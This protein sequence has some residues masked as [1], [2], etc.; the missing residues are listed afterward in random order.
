LSHDHLSTYRM[1]FEDPEKKRVPRR[2]RQQIEHSS[3][4]GLG[5][6]ETVAR[7]S[8]PQKP[9]QISPQCQE[10]VPQLSI[11]GQTEEQMSRSQQT[12]GQ[13]P[14]NQGNTE[15]SYS[16]R[17]TTG[18]MTKS[19]WSTERPSS[20]RQ[21]TRRVGEPPTF[22]DRVI[23]PPG[24]ARRAVPVSPFADAIQQSS[25]ARTR[26]TPVMPR[27]HAEDPG[28]QLRRQRQIPILHVYSALSERLSDVSSY[29]EPDSPSKGRGRKAQVPK[30]SIGIGIE[31]ELLLESRDPSKRETYVGR[32]GPI[33]LGETVAE[34]YN[35]LVPPSYPRMH[36]LVGCGKAHPCD[37][38]DTW[39]LMDDISIETTSAPCKCCIFCYYPSNH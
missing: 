4:Q 27:T 36:S 33:K 28:S 9:E 39:T 34:L 38:F 23:P 32:N 22:A 37:E 18:Q 15:Q 17:R 21:A 30:N 24:R 29:G 8:T 14:R 5:S 12:T 19:P 1:C 31:T 20:P 13:I 11:P 35:L 2:R 3:A 25:L 16:P 26:Q 6:H 10:I 7:I